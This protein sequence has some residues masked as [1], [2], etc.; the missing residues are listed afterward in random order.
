MKQPYPHLILSIQII[1]IH[2]SLISRLSLSR[3]VAAAA[4]ARCNSNTLKMLDRGGAPV[5]SALE[6]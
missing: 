3:Q 4:P 2:S 5:I 1:P 6:M